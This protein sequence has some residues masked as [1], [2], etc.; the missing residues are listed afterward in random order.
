M[1]MIQRDLHAKL[2]TDAVE[3]R[4]QLAGLLRPLNDAQLAEH[5]EPG[6]WSVG[7]VIEHLIVSDERS[8]APAIKAMKSARPD[9]NAPLR[10]WK[11]SFLGGMIASSLENPKKLK[12]PKVFLPTKAARGGVVEQLLAR[13]AEFVRVLDNAASLDWR[14]IRVRS[15]ALPPFAPTMNLGDAFRIHVVH[16][17]RHAGQIARLVS[18]L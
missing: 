4:E 1:Q 18:Q 8:A 11:S 7:E 15:G 14:A 17:R 2:R 12:S 9:A 5:P 6:G 3:L 16:V 13:E 10:T